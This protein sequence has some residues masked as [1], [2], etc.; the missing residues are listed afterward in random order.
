[1]TLTPE[2]ALLYPLQMTYRFCE[3]MKR[4]KHNSNKL[5]GSRELIEL[6]IS[7][8][9]HRIRKAEASFAERDPKD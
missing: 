1:L 6:P 8:Q 5:P 4:H 3:K 9:W 7:K 2:A